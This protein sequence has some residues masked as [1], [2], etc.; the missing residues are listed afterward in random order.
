MKFNLN[1]DIRVLYASVTYKH[2]GQFDL[3]QTMNSSGEVNLGHS[4]RPLQTELN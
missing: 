1:N 2:M 3:S 4:D